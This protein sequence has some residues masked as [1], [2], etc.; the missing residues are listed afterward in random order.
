MTADAN[1]YVSEFVINDQIVHLRA[2]IGEDF[3][4]EH[5]F[6][7]QLSPQSRYYRVLKKDAKV[8]FDTRMA[9]IAVI[10]SADGGEQ[11]VGAGRYLTD[12][13]DHCETV[14][15]VAEDWYV[16][17][18]GQVLMK[19]LI[20]FAQEHGKEFIY[21]IEPVDNTHMRVIARDLKM[22][23]QRDPD[24]PQFMRYELTLH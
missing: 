13:Y 12:E 16:P 21:A 15:R 3:A 7:K 22:D 2:A 20:D 10:E 11:T 5:R 19:M 23:A 17:G 18:L 8:D 14:I 4:E 6:I 1:K 24:N 9:F